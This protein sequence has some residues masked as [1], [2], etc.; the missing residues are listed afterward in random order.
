MVTDMSDGETR[1]YC[2]EHMSAFI[3][4]WAEAL[5]M[6]FPEVPADAA[7]SVIS[8]RS[9]SG[10]EQTTPRDAAEPEEAEAQSGV[11]PD[12]SNP[13]PAQP[14]RRRASRERV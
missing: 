7:D 4:V 10:E 1:C 3:A 2:P 14:V 13:Q 12:D 6:I 5:G 11:N 9:A 8:E